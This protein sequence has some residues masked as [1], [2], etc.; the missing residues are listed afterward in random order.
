MNL[1]FTS[2]I[3]NIKMK[4]FPI[5]NRNILTILAVAL[6]AVG[7]PLLVIISQQLQKTGEH[8]ATS[9]KRIPFGGS[10]WFL[11]GYDYPWNNYGYDFSN[12]SSNV[13]GQYS[14]VN[15]TFA[16]L[17]ANGTHVTRWF[18]FNDFRAAPLVNNN[19][20]MVTGLPVNFFQSFDDAL[21]IAHRHNIYLIPDMLDGITLLGKNST[22]VSV[23][24]KIFTDPIV[25]Q[26]FFDNAVKP[27]LQRYGN[28]RN[29]LA[30]S[31][32]NEPDFETQGVDPG[33]FYTIPYASM[34]DFMRQFTQYVHTYT[35][36]MATIENVSQHLI[37]FWTGL[38][39]DFYS[40]HFYDWMT[41]YWTDSDPVTTPASSLNLDKPVVIG[42][43]PSSGSRYSVQQYLDAIYINGYA[44]VLFWSANGGD[45]ASNY[46]GTKS[47]LKTWAQAHARDVNITTVRACC[48][49]S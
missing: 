13:H 46:S 20:G 12:S 41:Q 47:M 4:R 7:I 40:P 48:K 21:A 28:N 31:P 32:I 27:M 5:S 14:T 24:S 43:A 30:W 19:T 42:E 2:T 23:H 18:V 1:K 33:N 36:Q 22:N 9:N 38:G 6:L 16:D 49:K 35:S 8:A 15:N 3:D 29:I 26:S 45:S 25:R 34:Q 37:L 17:Q 44:G 11:V 39:F 10:K